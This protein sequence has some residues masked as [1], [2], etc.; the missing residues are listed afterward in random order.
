MQIRTVKILNAKERY[1]RWRLYDAHIFYCLS[2]ALK[3]QNQNQSTQQNEIIN[4]TKAK[5]TTGSR[6]SVC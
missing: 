3:K 1:V 5:N 6:G 2:L 4:K